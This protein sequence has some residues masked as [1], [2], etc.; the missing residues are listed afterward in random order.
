MEPYLLTCELLLLPG[1]AANKKVPCWNFSVLPRTLWSAPGFWKPY[2]TAFWALLIQDGSFPVTDGT[3]VVNNPERA[4]SAKGV[5][6]ASARTD[7]STQL[8][9][10]WRQGPKLC[11]L[12]HR[13]HSPSSPCWLQYVTEAKSDQ[14]GAC[15]NAI[16]S[17]KRS[18][19]NSISELQKKQFTLTFWHNRCP[20]LPPSH[21]NFCTSP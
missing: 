9:R 1:P 7:L 5:F 14:H 16:F 18:R 8:S 10:G 3:K 20:T 4:R 13:C 2:C 19:K 21:S 15:C 17:V 12:C 11:C 6:R